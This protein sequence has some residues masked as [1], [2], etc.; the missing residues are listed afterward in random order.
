VK[1]ELE[2][3]LPARYTSSNSLFRTSRASRGNVR[4]AAGPL[5]LLRREPMAALLAARC[6]HLAA[7]FGFHAHAKPMCFGAA[8]F[9]RLICTLWQN[10]PPCLYETC[11]ERVSRFFRNP[12][13]IQARKTPSLQREG[14]PFAALAA[15]SLHLP[16][17]L[18]G[19]PWSSRTARVRAAFGII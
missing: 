15:D 3:R 1:W 5:P 2:R 7:A 6:Q 9:P 12:F 4:P 11:R 14:G 18:R 13:K 10:I 17:W 8:A 19:L 16:R